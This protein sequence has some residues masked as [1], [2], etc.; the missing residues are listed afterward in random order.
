LASNNDPC[1]SIYSVLD[2]QAV[3]N[4]AKAKTSY[5]KPKPT[6]AFVGALATTPVA[7]ASATAAVE[8][9]G[10]FIAVIKATVGSSALRATPTI[11]Y[12]YP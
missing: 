9:T 12:L 6:A 10:E 2:I 8:V 4:I 3:P 7:T 11:N 5:L 1:Y